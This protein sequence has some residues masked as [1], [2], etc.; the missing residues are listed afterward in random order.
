MGGLLRSEEIGSIVVDTK[1]RFVSTGEA[2]RLAE[3]I[4]ASYY[5]LPRSDARKISEAIVEAAV[6]RRTIDD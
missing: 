1:S 2:A 3:I 5:Y 6:R 4:G